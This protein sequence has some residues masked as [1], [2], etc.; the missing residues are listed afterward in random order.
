MR[1]QSLD[2]VKASAGIAFSAWGHESVC[3]LTF[4]SFFLLKQRAAN[5][6]V[7]G[8]WDSQQTDRQV[9]WVVS[10]VYSRRDTIYQVHLEYDSKNT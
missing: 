3:Y 8:S 5:I 7:H 1:G 2:W 6:M 4:L 10:E 9:I